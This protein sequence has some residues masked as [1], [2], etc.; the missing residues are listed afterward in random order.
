MKHCFEIYVLTD[1]VERKQWQK[2]YDAVNA[3]SGVL[4][5]FQIVT[6]IKDNIVRYFLLS[7]QD[8]GAVANNLDGLLLRPV[9]KNAFHIPETR[10][11]KRM[12]QFVAGGNLLDFKEKYAVKSGEDLEYAV[13]NV[14]AVNKDKAVVKGRF[15]FKTAA[16]TY[17]VAPKMFTFLPT[18]L[19]A[20]DFSGNN[21]RYTK[22]TISKY[23]DI[24]KATPLFSSDEHGALF[25]VDGF[26][27]FNQQ[28]FIGLPQYEFDKHSFLVG[29]TGS[30]KSKLISLMIDRLAA[31]EQRN[32]YRVIVVDPPRCTSRGPKAHSI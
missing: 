5:K 13:L 10:K 8:L 6:S 15:Y 29:A 18:N 2:L 16:G 9:A 11:K 25:S 23:L 21:G 7:D 12:L 17:S 31:S 3:Y 24:E 1:S 28:Y 19:L 22:K 4:P 32:N 14:R 26:P 30:G 20:A 27:Y